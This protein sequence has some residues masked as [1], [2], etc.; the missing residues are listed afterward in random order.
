MLK[1]S[2]G[3][4]ISPTDALAHPLFWTNS[5][6]KDFLVAVGNQ[7]EFESWP[8]KRNFPE[9]DLE[10]DLKSLK[11]FQT[12][13]KC[14]SWDDSRNKLM[15]KFY[16][17]MKTWRNYDTTSVVDLVRLIRNGYSH[18]DSL[19]HKVRRMLLTNYA[20]L[21]YF[22]DLV[23]EVYKAVTVRGWNSRPQIKD[24]MTKQEHAS[25]RDFNHI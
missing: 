19:S 5:K 7:P 6:K 2:V 24:A 16:D 14:G 23:M 21:D 18:Y 4:R 1:K 3:E 9:T 10:R 15:P 11:V 8:S 17:E 12:V 20:Y 22:P 25:S 13:V